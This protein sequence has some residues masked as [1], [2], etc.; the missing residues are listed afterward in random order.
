MMINIKHIKDDQSV[1]VTF[2][3]SLILPLQ[4]NKKPE[5]KNAQYI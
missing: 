4:K 3:P 5:M 1:L 2:L